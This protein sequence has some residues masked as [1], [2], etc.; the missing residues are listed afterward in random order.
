[1]EEVLAEVFDD[2]D[3]ALVDVADMLDATVEGEEVD[4]ARVETLV[5]V[6]VL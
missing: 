6:G 4:I 2:L 5:G 3:D 1:M